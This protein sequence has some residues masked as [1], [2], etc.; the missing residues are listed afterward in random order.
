M[1][2]QFLSVGAS[3]D[4]VYFS[5]SHPKAVLA[6]HLEDDVSRKP[7]LGMI[8]RARKNLSIDLSRSILIGDKDRNIQPDVAAYV[9]TNLLFASERPNELVGLSYDPIPNLH[10]AKSYLWQGV[11]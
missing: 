2:K 8:R 1:C 5:T 3:I 11:Q 6:K 7:H 9:C 4:R 10:E